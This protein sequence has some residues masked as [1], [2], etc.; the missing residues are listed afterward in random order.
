MS[1]IRWW[2]Q[3]LDLSVLVSMGL[4]I[5]QTEFGNETWNM[6]CRHNFMN[7]YKDDGKMSTT[8]KWEK[9][10]VCECECECVCVYVRESVCIANLLWLGSLGQAASIQTWG[11]IENQWSV[12]MLSSCFRFMFLWEIPLFFKVPMFC[13]VFIWF[14]YRWHLQPSS[15]S[16]GYGRIFICS[17]EKMLLSY[18]SL[19]QIMSQPIWFSCLLRV[20]FILGLIFWLILMLH[21]SESSKP[22]IFLEMSMQTIFFDRFEIHHL[23]WIKYQ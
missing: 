5:N 21:C 4:K 6:V 15:S 11:T 19:I 14:V 12:L 23:P 22:W 16:M 9:M 20:R 1:I 13:S 8:R 18:H 10:S 2:V 17:V 3:K 7:V